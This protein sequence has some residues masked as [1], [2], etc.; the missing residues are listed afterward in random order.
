V[1]AKRRVL[2]RAKSGARS[3]LG[4]EMRTRAVAEEVLAQGGEALLVVDDGAGAAR[5]RR[6]GLDAWSLEER[7]GWARERA[8]GAWLDGFV[9]WTEELRA[10]A[11]AGTP[12][13]LVE[14]RT[15]AREWAR[16]VVHPALHH[17]PDRWESLH[18][19]R[20]LAGADWIPLSRAVREAPR[21]AERDVELLVTFGGS[22]PLGSTE[23]VLA[24]LEDGAGLVVAVGP[25]MQARRAAIERAVRSRGGR[26]LAAGEP[27]APWMARAR[28]AITALGT[29]LYELAYLGT[30]AL[31]LANHEEDR[32]ALE[33]YR[34]HG[35]HRPL[36]I[37]SALDG[38]ALR[39]LLAGELAALGGR[40]C[41]VPEGLGRGAA[42]LAERLLAPAREVLAARAR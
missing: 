31:I 23:R 9:D 6:A 8:S 29:T 15:P 12:S 21:P 20:V 4:H 36:G 2:L 22:D 16:F 28:A 37:A 32:A 35:P 17:V 1:S 26:T 7:P 41:A 19:A 25:H 5:L 38:P 3:G 13:H 33:H 34:Q 30:P 11:R 39:G 27:L 18:A 24:A 40:P 14:N 10:L 42:R